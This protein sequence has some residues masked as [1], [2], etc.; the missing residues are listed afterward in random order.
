VKNLWAPIIRPKRGAEWINWTCVRLTKRDAMAA[1]C[2]HIPP[3][4]HKEWLQ[5]VRFARV[6]I[7]ESQNSKNSQP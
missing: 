6:T 5:N 3:N 4:L 7:I 1:V 2:D